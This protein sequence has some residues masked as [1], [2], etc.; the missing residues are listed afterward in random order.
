MLLELEI[1]RSKMAAEFATQD[2]NLLSKKLAIQTHE[3]SEVESRFRRM[4]DHAPVGMFH[5]DLSG[6]VLYANEDYYRYSFAGF[7]FIFLA[8]LLIFAGSL[9]IL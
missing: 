7:V 3:T 2:W 8:N 9:N 6:V 4:A 5:F 1:S